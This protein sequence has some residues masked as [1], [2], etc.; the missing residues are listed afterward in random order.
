MFLELERFF[1]FTAQALTQV[2]Y[3][4]NSDCVGTLCF[5]ILCEFMEWTFLE[6]TLV[7][8]SPVNVPGIHLKSSP[9]EPEHNN[10]LLTLLPKAAFKRCYLSF[11]RQNADSWQL[12]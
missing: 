3:Y 11:S 4:I 7:K 6:Q 12:S 2:V 10:P 5:N 1:L 9:G 8:L